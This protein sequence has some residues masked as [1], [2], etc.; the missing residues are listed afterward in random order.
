MKGGRR[1]VKK[2]DRRIEK[3]GG[4]K[5]VKKGGRRREEKRRETCKGIALSAGDR[6]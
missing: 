3:K 2:G 5:R 1:R 4:R 6:G